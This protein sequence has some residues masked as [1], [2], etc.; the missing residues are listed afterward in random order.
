MSLVTDIYDQKYSE[1]YDSRYLTSDYAKVASDFELSLLNDIISEDTNWLDVGC[2][3]GYFLSFFQH[4]NRCGIDI[5]ADM[6]CVAKERNKTAEFIEGDFRKVLPELNKQ[7]N[8]VSC[9][10]TPY[11]YIDSMSEF[12]TFMKNLIAVTGV[13]GTLFIPVVDLEDLRPHTIVEYNMYSEI[14]QGNVQLTSTTWSFIEDNGKI[15]T[16]LVAPQIGYFVDQL[17][18]FFETITVVRYP[19]YQPG[20]VS[21]KAILAKNKY[22]ERGTSIINDEKLM[23]NKPETPT[24]PNKN[25]INDLTIKELIKEIMRRF[26]NR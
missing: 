15:H 4:I 26:F 3:T 11:N 8:V 21:K 20:W 23:N 6:L 12:D 14:H 19:V 24:E 2:G 22:S 10:W 9:M 25:A 7:W 13:G 16:H 17:N 1:E 18:G 5:S